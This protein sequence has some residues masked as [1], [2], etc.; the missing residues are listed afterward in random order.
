[1][2]LTALNSPTPLAGQR[3]LV[4]TLSPRGEFFHVAKGTGEVHL[5]FCGLE[6]WPAGEAPSLGVPERSVHCLESLFREM[7]NLLELKDLLT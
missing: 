5:L 2:T 3:P 6:R 7:V 4:K 1:M